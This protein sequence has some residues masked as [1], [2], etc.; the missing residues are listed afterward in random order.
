MMNFKCKY[1]QFFHK[2]Q[3]FFYYDF[4]WWNKTEE[5]FFFSQIKNLK[6]AACIYILYGTSPSGSSIK[7]V[8][9]QQA[10]SQAQPE[11]LD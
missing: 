1:W 9:H 5:K 8:E 3:S 6:S 11:W 10:E 7:F 2:I 4:M